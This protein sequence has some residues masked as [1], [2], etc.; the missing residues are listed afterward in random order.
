MMYVDKDSVVNKIG[1]TGY[2][3]KKYGVAKKSKNDTSNNAIFSNNKYNF[4]L[5]VYDSNERE[6]NGGSNWIV[7]NIDCV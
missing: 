1:N 2:L 7:N 5:V 4:H 3:K 6:R